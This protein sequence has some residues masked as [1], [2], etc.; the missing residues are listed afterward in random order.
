MKVYIVMRNGPEWGEVVD[1]FLNKNSAISVS[2]ERNNKVKEL[3]A[4]R[5]TSKCWRLS[6]VEECLSTYE[7]VTKTVQQ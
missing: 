2:T 3:K 7:V 5:D 4:K 6:D 1:V